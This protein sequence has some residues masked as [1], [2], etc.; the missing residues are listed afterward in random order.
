MPNDPTVKLL[1]IVKD[2]KFADSAWEFFEATV[3]D[4]STYILADMGPVKYLEKIV[5]G[6]V[7]RFAYL[8]PR[9]IQSLTGYDAI[10]LHSLNEFALEVLARIPPD[11]PVLWIGMGYDYYYDLLYASEWELLK[12]ETREL[13]Q[14]YNPNF[15]QRGPVNLFKRLLLPLLYPNFF[16]KKELLNKIDLFAPVLESE[17]CRISEKLGG[18]HPEFVRW[19]YG[20]TADLVDGAIDTTIVAGRDILIGNSATPTN[21]HLEIFRLLAGLG[22]P[23]GS[24]VVVPLSYGDERYRSKIIEAGRQY[25]GER[26]VPITEVL[27]FR[28]YVEM[29][30]GCPTVIMN[31]LRQQ[32]AGN[33]IISLFLGARVY[34]DPENPLYEEYRNQGLSLRSLDQLPEDTAVLG[35]PLEADTIHTNRRILSSSKGREF[36][37]RNTRQVIN[38]LMDIKEQKVRAPGK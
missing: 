36:H 20:K 29:L 4:Q 25:F 26:F 9:F 24:R 27:P 11:V 35:T 23:E 10:I 19:N 16:R 31:H 14:S 33:L 21:N 37:E 2:D 18:L 7:H 22:L 30:R 5:P 32:A 17:Y 38:K 15:G 13:V 34:L 28:D 8:S 12:A 3:P 6:K 1:H